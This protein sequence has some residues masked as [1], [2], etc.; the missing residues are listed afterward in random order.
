MADATDLK[1]VDR[2]VVRVRLPPSAPIL[3]SLFQTT[4]DRF[5]D[6]SCSQRPGSWDQDD[7]K[8]TTFF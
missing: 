2:K 7:A 4:W 6:S 3:I 1:S 5:L 8:M